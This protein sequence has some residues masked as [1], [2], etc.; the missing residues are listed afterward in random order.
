MLRDTAG[1]PQ[2][3]PARPPRF[4]NVVARHWRGDYPLGISYW[5]IYVLAALALGGILLAVSLLVSIHAGVEPRIDFAALVAT[6]LAV[7]AVS[8][9]QYVGVWRSAARRFGERVRLG[10]HGVWP[11]LAMVSIVVAV[12][13]LVFRFAEAGL[14]PIVDAARIAFLDDPAVPAYAIRVMRNGTEAEI[15]GGFKR[16]LT[17]ELRRILEASPQIKVVHF[18]SLGGRIAEARKLNALVRERGLTTY[19][20]SRCSS[21]CVVAFAGGRERWLHVEGELGFHGPGA[22]R[23]SDGALADEIGEHKEAFTA[24]GFDPRFVDRALATPSGDMWTP[25]PDELLAAKVITAVSDGTHFAASGYGAHLTREGMAA[26]LTE[27]LPILQTMRER[28][29]KDYVGLIDVYYAAYTAGQT[30][31]EMITAARGSSTI[32]SSPPGRSP[33]TPCWWSRGRLLAEQYAALGAKDPSL[34]YGYAISKRNQVLAELPQDLAERQFALEERIIATAAPRPEP[35][36]AMLA[37]VGEKVQDSLVEREPLKM[38]LLLLLS[39]INPSQH[40]DYC[41]ASIAW[42]EFVTGLPENEAALFLRHIF[43][44][45]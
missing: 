45:K 36:A 27:H 44:G 20:A 11:T 18:D 15:T 34:C 42:L 5:I 4:N 29:P 43:G 41:D 8:A 26:K 13:A 25:S 3:A 22:R 7:L 35:S 10:K 21:A 39:P 17:D 6:W 12:P 32:S 23:I 14:P 31:V 28:L 37:P 33:M 24:A 40:A 19:V 1:S 38:R 9:W 2:P 30:E 16:G